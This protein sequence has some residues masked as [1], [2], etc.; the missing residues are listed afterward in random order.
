MTAAIA[1]TV[2][3]P[4]VVSF[5]GV[6]PALIY[7]KGENQ[8]VSLEGLG[9]WPAG[10]DI[11]RLK[12]EGGDSVPEG[13]LRQIVP[14]APATHVEALRRFGTITYEQAATPAFHWAREALAAPL[15]QVGPP[16]LLGNV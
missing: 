15:V 14:A 10:T 4:D 2:L 7:M 5:A 9:Y 3:Q 6:L 16:T 13:I 12:A 1:L 8:V 11:A